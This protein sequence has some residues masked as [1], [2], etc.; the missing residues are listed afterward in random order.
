M[1]NQIIRPDYGVFYI[2]T[3]GSKSICF[4]YDFMV[5]GIFYV[6]DNLFTISSIMV[7]DDVEYYASVDFDRNKLNEL[8]SIID[9][10]NLKSELQS[11]FAGEFVIPIRYDFPEMLFEVG[12]ETHLGEPITNN[13]ETYIPFIADKFFGYISHQLIPSKIERL[14]PAGI[15]HVMVNEDRP[16]G[17]AVESEDDENEETNI[18]NAYVCYP[19]MSHCCEWGAVYLFS[20]LEEAKT[21]FAW[22]ASG[23]FNFAIPIDSLNDLQLKAANLIWLNYESSFRDGFKSNEVNID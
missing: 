18:L 4:F 15:T 5:D 22:K 7:F 9:N 3:F 11:R 14:F 19:E 17:F 21:S 2:N 8:I 23:G 6:D 10:V 13:N 16:V 12:I 1:S 20:S